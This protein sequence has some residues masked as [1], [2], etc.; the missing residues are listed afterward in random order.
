MTASG[1][2]AVA[3]QALSAP[4]RTCDEVG[5]HFQW[6]RLPSQ[7]ARPASEAPATSAK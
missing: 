2:R 3:H 6:K 4:S 5:I 7:M 1:T